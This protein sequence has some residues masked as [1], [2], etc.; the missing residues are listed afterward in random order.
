MMEL[1][2]AK[3]N[4]IVGGGYNIRWTNPVMTW[5]RKLS[6]DHYQE[7]LE[8]ARSLL[9]TNGKV[10]DECGDVVHEAIIEALN[11]I[12]EGY[13]FESQAIVTKEDAAWRLVRY[14]D[15]NDITRACAGV[16]DVFGSVGVDDGK[17]ASCRRGIFWDKALPIHE[18]HIQSAAHCC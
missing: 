11:S 16:G 9:P 14:S 13:E 15:T 8:L 4:T 12:H 5:L 18:G 10:L 2:T 1:K 17:M 3:S 6:N 7:W